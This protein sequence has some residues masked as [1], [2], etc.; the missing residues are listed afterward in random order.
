MSFI[1]FVKRPMRIAPDVYILRPLE[2]HMVKTFIWE[3]LF[4]LYVV[5]TLGF[6]T[7]FCAYFKDAFVIVIS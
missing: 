2:S 7:M 1:P 3:K 6:Q 5:H 4:F